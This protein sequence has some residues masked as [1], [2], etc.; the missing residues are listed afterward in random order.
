MKIFLTFTC[1]ML[2]LVAQA[3]DTIPI[4]NTVFHGINTLINL[5]RPVTVMPVIPATPVI[6]QSVEP[7]VQVVYP[8]VHYTYPGDQIVYGQG[9][10]IY[11]IRSGTYYRYFPPPLPPPMY[12][13]RVKHPGPNHHRKA[14]DHPRRQERRWK[15]R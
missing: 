2:I 13:P 1:G 12:H 7:T 14:R 15:H 8:T 10:V 3:N 9:G 4:L 5:S 11:V 6:V